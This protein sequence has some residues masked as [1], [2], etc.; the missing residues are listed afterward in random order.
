MPADA[1]KRIAGSGTET[2]T[3]KFYPS[4]H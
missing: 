3:V 2:T 1:T 4:V